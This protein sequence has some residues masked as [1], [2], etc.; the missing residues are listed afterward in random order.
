MVGLCDVADG[1]RFVTPLHALQLW[2]Y[3]FDLCVTLQ[4]QL[5][6]RY[7]CYSCDI[8]VLTAATR[9]CDNVFLLY[10]C[11]AIV[12][13]VPSTSSHVLQLWHRDFEI[14]CALQRQHYRTRHTWGALHQWIFFYFVICVYNIF[15]NTEFEIGT[16]PVSYRYRI[17]QY[18][19][20][21]KHE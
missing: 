18:R 12:W 14:C 16:I 11:D 20:L 7:T 13:H 21:R 19:I 15:T 2:Q 1:S 10:M 6:L 4:R 3:G 5:Q 9:Y 17:Y 8:K